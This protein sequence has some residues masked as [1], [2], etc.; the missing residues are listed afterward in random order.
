MC[1]YY[2]FIVGMCLSCDIVVCVVHTSVMC[3]YTHIK[4]TCHK[5][6][7]VFPS[8]PYLSVIVS[9]ALF[10]CLQCWSSVCVF[11]AH[12]VCVYLEFNVFVCMCV[13]EIQLLCDCVAF[14]F[15]VCICVSSSMS[16]C[17]IQLLCVYV[18]FNVCVCI[19]FNV[20]VYIL[21]IVFVCAAHVS[22]LWFGDNGI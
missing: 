7:S 6:M 21:F 3:E 20:F 17:W 22:H 13:C 19:R 15:F 12:S 2:L 11:Q 9:P 5:Y 16:V 8:C 18:A 4:L 10:I 1:V 14:N